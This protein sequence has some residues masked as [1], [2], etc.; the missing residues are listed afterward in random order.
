MN[1]FIN[2]SVYP[3]CGVH[4]LI[5]TCMIVVFLGGGVVLAI[6]FDT[7]HTNMVLV[8]FFNTSSLI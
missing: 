8:Y 7:N 1:G 5:L 6:L 3:D 2:G 4:W